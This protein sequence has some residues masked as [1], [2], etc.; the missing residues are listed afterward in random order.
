M[1]K[2][3]IHDYSALRIEG[4][5][6]PPDFLHDVVN[7][8]APHQKG[9]DYDL[10]PS[11]T[12]QEELSRY[13]RIAQDRYQVYERHRQRSDPNASSAIIDAWLVPLLKSVL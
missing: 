6:L 5:L 8:K 9:E 3:G 12:I 1:I 7:L 10:S 2:K 11:L 4:G 13:W